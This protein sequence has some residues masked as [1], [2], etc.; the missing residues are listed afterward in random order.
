MGAWGGWALAPYTASMGRDN[1][2]HTHLSPKG[3]PTFKAPGDFFNF[4]GKKFW[5]DFRP[6][7]IARRRDWPRPPPI[8][9]TPWWPPAGPAP[10]FREH[11][12][13]A[14]HFRRQAGSE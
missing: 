4:F 9:R 13:H 5:Q 10:G 3:C 8:C 11:P 7:I 14:E 12:A 6:K 2:S 1:R